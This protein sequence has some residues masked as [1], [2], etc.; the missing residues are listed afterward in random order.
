ML[1][2]LTGDEVLRAT[3]STL[4]K[5]NVSRQDGHKDR[6]SLDSLIGMNFMLQG[7]L[8]ELAVA[9]IT[10]LPWTTEYE[11]FVNDVGDLEVRSRSLVQNGP[12]T[13]FRLRSYELPK[14]TASQKFVFCT[15]DDNQVHIEGWATVGE[16]ARKWRPHHIDGDNYDVY[17]IPETMLHPIETVLL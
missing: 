1:I 9:L 14:H 3:K 6:R 2:K 16:L 13:Q 5:I 8:A 12:P 11:P 17:Y 4:Y 10:G 15:V 7:A